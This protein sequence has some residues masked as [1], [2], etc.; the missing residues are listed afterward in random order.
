MNVLMRTDRHILLFTV[1]KVVGAAA[2][3]MHRLRQALCG[4]ISE[5]IHVLNSL[6]GVQIPI[7]WQH[8]E[9]EEKKGESRSK[10]TVMYGDRHCCS[11]KAIERSLACH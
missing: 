1:N 11:L 8:K 7:G 10:W 2:S 9:Q 6:H 4:H 3:N 5:K